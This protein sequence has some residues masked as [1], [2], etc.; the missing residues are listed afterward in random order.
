[1]AHYSPNEIVDMIMILGE[2]Q[3]VYV[4]AA[5][6]YA[7]RFPN[8]RHPSNVTIRDLTNRVRNGRLHRECR[9]VEYGEHDVRV[10]TVLAMIHL[11]PHISSRQ[12]QRESG[13]SKSTVLRIL[14]A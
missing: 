5:A 1:M 10:I 12:I 9:H 8:R 13:I 11:N 7:E 6:L 4:A 14:K 3:G 2:C